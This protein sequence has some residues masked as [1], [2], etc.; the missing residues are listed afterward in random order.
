MLEHAV[1]ALKAGR[2]PLLDQPLAAATEVELRLPAFL[3]EAYVGDVHVRLSLYKRIAAAE[4]EAALDDL[5]AEIQ[6]RFGPA[7][8]AA[9]SLLRIARLKLAARALGVRRLDLGPQ[10]G[11]AA[12]CLPPRRS[13]PRRP[14]RR[15]ARSTTS[16]SSSSARPPPRA[17]PRTGA[18][19][20]ASAPSRATNRPVTRPRSGASWRSCRRAPGSSPSSRT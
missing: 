1:R 11:T 15:A 8:P 20:R 6:D 7:P 9:Q 16:S 4:S 18:R 3:P 14:R 10:G 12:R 19:R 17:P 2:E 5:A 13:R